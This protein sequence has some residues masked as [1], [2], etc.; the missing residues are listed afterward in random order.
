MHLSIVVP[1][2]NEATNATKVASELLPV[3]QALAASGPVQIVFVDDGSTDDTRAVFSRLADVATERGVSAVVVPHDRNR[4]LG[5]ALRTGFGASQG[6]VIVTT[7]SDA[8][9]RFEEIPAILARLTDDVDI[10]TASPYHPDGA[11]ANVPSHRLVLSRGSSWIYR[12]LVSSSIH[13]YT[14]LFRAYRRRVIETV[15]FASDGFLAGTELLVNAVLAGYRVAEYPTVLHSRAHGVSKAKLVRTTRAHLQFQAR[16]LAGRL[17]LAR[18]PWQAV[19]SG[20]AG[21]APPLSSDLVG[22]SS[23]QKGR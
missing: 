18:G 10:V 7:D 6:D 5:A 17:H 3:A 2:F 16:V 11:V 23:R 12:R 20:P 19:A 15:P 21:Q 13:T 14:A 4:G 1:C 8:T 22:A 9:Y